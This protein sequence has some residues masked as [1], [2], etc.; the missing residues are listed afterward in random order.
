M[1]KTVLITD[2]VHESLIEAFKEANWEVHYDPEI[3]YDQTINIIDQYHGLIVN[4]KILANKS[5]LDKAVKLEWIGRLGSG[6]EIID[7]IYAQEK[8]IKVYSSPEGNSNAVGEHALAL[9]LSL[10]T[11]LRLGDIQVRNK[12]WDR[13]Q[14]RGW[15]LKSKTIGII[16]FGHTGKAFAKKL[17]GMEMVILVYDKYLNNFGKPLLPNS[18]PSS[19]IYEVTLEDLKLNSDIISFHLPLTPETKHFA[20]YNFLKSCKKDLVLINTSRGNVVNTQDLVQ[21]MQEG[22]VKAVGMDV[23]E[24]E[25][26][27]TYSEEENRWFE[28]L[29]Q[30]ENGV[31][32]PH[33]AGWTIE[34]K[35]QLSEVLIAKILGNV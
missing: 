11:K 26:P 16:G 22:W 4:S 33:V 19:G 10:S 18:N 31:F 13:E 32:S 8:G 25:K 7:L 21:T 17:A 29:V 6:L 5:F 24:N 9:L 2:S 15:E 1:R 14:V 23:F 34:S 12:S 27:N 35:K 30:Q 28:G 3:T 20:D